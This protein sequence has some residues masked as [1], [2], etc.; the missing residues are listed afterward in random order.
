MQMFFLLKCFFS[1]L[2]GFIRKILTKLF[3]MKHSISEHQKKL[4]HNFLSE[5]Q[6]LLEE[7]SIE[8]LYIYSDMLIKENEST[9]LISNNDTPKFLSRHVCDSLVPY[10]FYKDYIKDDFKW[11]DIGSGGGCP[12]IPLC[13]ILPKVEFF[14]VEPRKKRALF[15]EK[16][17][18]NLKLNNFNVIDKKFESA[19]FKNL[20]IVSARA[21][22]TF[23]ND[24]ARAENSLK[25]GGKFITLKS[26]TSILHLKEDEKNKIIQYELPEESQQYAIVSRGKYV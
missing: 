12:V 25:V 2:I 18:N 17:K 8:K 20:D 19:N 23:E 3:H 26:L 1:V 14:A 10:I 6:V 22:S 5:H 4:L 7:K 16:V 9:N 11:A 24:W 15:L 21:V 13:I